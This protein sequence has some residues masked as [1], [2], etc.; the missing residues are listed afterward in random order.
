MK[1]AS[2]ILYSILIILNIGCV[3]ED[4]Q[5]NNEYTMYCIAAGE[6]YSNNHSIV[7]SIYSNSKRSITADIVFHNTCVYDNKVLKEENR[8]DINKLIGISDAYNHTY[9]SAR[10][11]WRCIDNNTIEI[12]TYT[13]QK[14]NFT[15]D[16][17]A[18][19]YPGETHRY[20]IEITDWEYRYSFDNHVYRYTRIEQ[21][22]GMRYGLY[23][24]FG[25]SE[26]AMQ[27]MCIEIRSDL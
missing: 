23:P 5:D 9:A 27:D 21:Y 11:G 2:R 26:C 20:T 16:P 8:Y 15:S 17:I 3:V 18:S 6:H 12:L 19:V 4:R 13:R 24:Y 1:G 25:G 7:S 14:G 22:N 10:F